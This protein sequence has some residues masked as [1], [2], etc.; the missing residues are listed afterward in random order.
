MNGLKKNAAAIGRSLD[1]YYRDDERTHRMDRLNAAF[2]PK[3]GLAFDIGAHVGDR[4]A[5][6]LRLGASAVALEPQPRVF[7]ALKLIHGRTSKAVLLC[8]AAGAQPGEITIHLNSNNPT[9]STASQDLITTAA[10]TKEWKDQAWD[11][12]IQVPVTTMDHLIAKHGA[13]DFVK[14]DVEGHELHVLLGLSTPIP[15]L[16][17]EFTT[18]QRDVALACINRLSELARYEFNVSLGEEHVLRHQNWIGQSD[19][20]DQITSFPDNVNSGDIYARHVL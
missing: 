19:L 8:Q 17:F 3:G 10:S 15:A 1:I 5:S 2:V 9:V 6:F 7:R 14:I 4:T 16:S 12:Q 11:S 20:R 13:P 18:I